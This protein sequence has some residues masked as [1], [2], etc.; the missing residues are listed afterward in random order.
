MVKNAHITGKLEYREGDGPNIVIRPGAVQVE[1]TDM[2]ATISWTDAD[3]R[4]SAAIPIA[5]FRRYVKSKVIEIGA[6]TD[7]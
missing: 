1:E 6:E 2:D 4:G 7:A 5:D 3:S